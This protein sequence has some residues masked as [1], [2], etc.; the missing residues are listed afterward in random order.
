[1]VQGPRREVFLPSN[2]ALLG[3]Q[4][5]H[6][7]GHF[8]EEHVDAPLQNPLPLQMENEG[9]GEGRRRD[10]HQS[11]ETLPPRAGVGGVMK[12]KDSFFSSE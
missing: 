8:H 1:M 7:D 4:P 9:S 11:H 2:N 10:A 5:H 6:I 12:E 3:I